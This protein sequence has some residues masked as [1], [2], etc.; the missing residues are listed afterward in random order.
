MRV[1]T[2]VCV[3]FTEFL[4]TMLTF[5]LLISGSEGWLAQPVLQA[6]CSSSLLYASWQATEKERRREIGGERWEGTGEKG[7]RDKINR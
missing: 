6:S 3:R 1:Y 2:G 7:Q 5:L 4:V